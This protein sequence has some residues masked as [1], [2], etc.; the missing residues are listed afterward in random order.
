MGACKFVAVQHALVLALKTE[1]QEFRMSAMNENWP[2][3]FEALSRQ[4][5]NA[6]TEMARQAGTGQQHQ[7]P[8]WQDAMDMWAPWAR[9]GRAQTDE[10]ISRMNA[11]TGAWFGQMQELAKRF[12]GG[13]SSPAD[14]A[15]EWKKALGIEAGGFS[16]PFA[17]MFQNMSGPSAHGMDQWMK[18]AAPWLDAMRSGGSGMFNM[19][20]FGL[21]REQQERWQALGK[22]QM[23]Y[24]QAMSGYNAQL[25]ECGKRAFTKF[26][27]KLA[28]RSEPGRQLDST[29]ALFDL[30]I[31]AA[32]EAWSDVALTPE[33]RTAYGALV[34]AQTRVRAGVQGEVER[35]TGMFGIPTRTE[36]NSSHKKVTQLERELRDL[37]QRLAALE[38]AL[39]ATT[40]TAKADTSAQTSA[41]ASDAKSAA[42]SAAKSAA[43]SEAATAAAAAAA[44]AAAK[45]AA[46]A[47]ATSDLLAASRAQAS[48]VPRAAAPKTAPPKPAAKKLAPVARAA[49]KPTKSAPASRRA[50]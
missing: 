7:M 2:Q 6:W 20:A 44:G 26:E 8:G 12:S 21:Q 28:E 15:S 1:F 40:K 34:N 39:S 38:A 19:P 22:A 41:A 9:D 50:K 43:A 11:Q 27:D 29:R 4:Y 23:D 49:T 18:Q 32:E 47:T 14:I 48:E 25:M 13:Q 33:F 17:N 5:W 30:W 10:T 16:N 37:K 36:V 31:D 46:S 3:D 24:Q 42:T 35:T 45:A